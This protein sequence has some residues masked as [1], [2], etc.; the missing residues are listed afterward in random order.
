LAE[1][2]DATLSVDSFADPPRSIGFIPVVQKKGDHS[3]ERVRDE[4]DKRVSS[5]AQKRRERSKEEG[6]G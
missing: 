5:R 6:V 1:A 3:N 4:G 2:D